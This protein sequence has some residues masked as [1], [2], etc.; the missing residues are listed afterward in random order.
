M[1]CLKRVI[2]VNEIETRAAYLDWINEFCGQ[3]YT[4]ANAPGGV[5]LA[6]E[7]LLK[8]SKLPVGVGSESVSDLSRSY[9]IAQEIPATIRTNLYP[10][11]RMPTVKG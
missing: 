10:Y 3:E 9:T 4:E 1:P 2:V 11:R 6:I 8:M 5:K 7:Q